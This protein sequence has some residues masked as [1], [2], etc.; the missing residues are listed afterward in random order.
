MFAS[1]LGNDPVKFYLEKMIRN[2]Q[3]PHALLFVGPDGIGKTLFAKKI[4]DEL[5]GKKENHPDFHVIRPEG[6]SGFHS[7]ESIRE[8]IDIV[9]T[10]PFEA[11]WKICVIVDADRMQPAAANGLLKTLEEP[12][13]DTILILLTSVLQE[14]L[15]TIRSRCRLIQFQPLS[16]EDIIAILKTKEIPIHFAK[17]ANGSAGRAIELSKMGESSLFRFL[18]E[19]TVSV[20][21]IEKEID[22]EDPVQNN[23]NIE[24]LFA[25][26]LMWHRDQ[27]ARELQQPLFFPDAPISKRKLPPLHKV[28]K[29]IEEARLAFSRNI[30]LAV[31]L[32]QIFHI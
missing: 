23:R 29:G 7:I 27:I 10:M 16:E 22:C 18:S 8:M 31:C 20:E 4:A 14:L 32:E 13:P 28:E 1:I 5:L 9:H 25:S 12:N 17:Q 30:R 26:I 3:L 2:E 11:K 15:P 24:Y 6:K 21:E 19:R